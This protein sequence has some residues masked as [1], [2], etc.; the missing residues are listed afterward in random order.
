[1]KDYLDD[2][3]SYLKFNLNYTDTTVDSYKR[4]IE[5]FYNFIAKEAINYLDVDNLVI[6]NFLTHELRDKISKKSCR[7][8]ICALKKYYEFLY[9]NKYIINN[10][11]VFVAPIKVEKTF[12]KVLNDSQIKQL[13]ADNFKRQDKLV[14]R[15]QVILE[16]LFSCGVRVSEL[17]NIK[18]N[19]LNLKQRI[20]R[21]FGK[22][23]KERIVPFT[24]ECENAIDL[25]LNNLRGSL[26]AQNKEYNP[27]LLV[28]QKGQKLTRRG[29]EYILDQ[30]EIRCAD[31]YGL[32]PHMLRHSFAT[33]LLE[34]GADLRL[35]QELLGHSSIN[36]TQIYTHVSK[37][38]LINAYKYSHPRA[39]ENKTK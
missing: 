16:I 24:R 1:M 4:D 7:R 8:R 19:D 26:V 17:I 25:Y 10:P 27:Y 6:R 34:Q 13:L 37:E 2:F 3:I 23:Q 11:F 20:V 9:K 18:I 33:H 31:F 29:V 32:H 15:D 38:N 22:G 35:I 28:N 14:L 12:P 30:I 5:K 39:R 21:I 36:S